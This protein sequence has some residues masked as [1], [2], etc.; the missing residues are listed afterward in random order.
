MY[1]LCIL[2]VSILPGELVCNSMSC[3]CIDSSGFYLCW[4][5]ESYQKGFVSICTH[6]CTSN[7]NTNII[8]NIISRTTQ[9]IGCYETVVFSF[10]LCSVCTVD[11][12]ALQGPLSCDG[13]IRT[14]V[15]NYSSVEFYDYNIMNNISLPSDI[16]IN[17]VCI[18]TKQNVFPSHAIDHA[19]SVFILLFLRCVL[20]LILSCGSPSTIVSFLYLIRVLLFLLVLTLATGPVPQLVLMASQ[21]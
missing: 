16:N 5:T 18:S 19:W 8:R 2:L 10:S 4:S 3:C 13:D 9:E 12:V 7:H 6:E 21:A 20:R 11:N 15:E 14:L 17:E 1:I